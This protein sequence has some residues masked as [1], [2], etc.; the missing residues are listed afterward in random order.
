[1]RSGV[2]PPYEDT[3][4]G[5]VEGISDSDQSSL[6]RDGSVASQVRTFQPLESLT[7]LTQKSLIYRDVDRDEW[8][9]TT[10]VLTLKGRLWSF[11]L[12]VLT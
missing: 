10:F 12:L 4:T 6:R 3:D 7:F 11:V 9:F 8:D 2:W 5:C 1:M